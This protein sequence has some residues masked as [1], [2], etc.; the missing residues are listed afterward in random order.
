M[1]EK[2]TTL[3]IPTKDRSQKIITLLKYLEKNKIIFKDIFIIDSSNYN[4][5]IK[6]K[7]FI[8]NKKIKIYDTFPSTTFQRN[9][10]L[11]KV[12][13]SKYVLFLDDDIK[14]KK[15]SFYHMNNG[16]IKYR[17]FKNICSYAFNLKSDKNKFKNEKLK[18]NFFTEFVGL[19]SSKPGKVLKSGWHT[20][21]SN[22]NRD[23]VV[24]WIYSGATIFVLNKIKKMKFENLNKGFNYLEDLHFSYKLTKKKMKHIVIAKATVNNPNFIDRNDI[25]FGYIEIINRYKFVNKFNLSK[26]LFYLG[27]FLK[28]NYLFLGLINFRINWISR[29]IGNYLG[30]L[31]C[32]Y[33]DL[34]KRF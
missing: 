25:S 26:V 2:K 14:L 6:I 10:G 17:N 29:F 27:A 21:I 5:K 31:Y 15:K 20:K 16:I 19:Y 13:N 3:I 33:N 30:I 34:K 23:T 11:K 8:K 18:V 12:K 28:S 9:L 32:S 7:K 1:F 4:H 24:E 22:L